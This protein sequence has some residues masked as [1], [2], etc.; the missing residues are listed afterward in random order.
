MWLY[1]KQRSSNSS[2]TI[3]NCLIWQ[4]S[5]G[6]QGCAMTHH[7][8]KCILQVGSNCKHFRPEADPFLQA[9]PAWKKRNSHINCPNSEMNCPRVDILVY[10]KG[11]RKPHHRII[12]SPLPSSFLSPA[13]A[14][15]PRNLFKAL[16]DVTHDDRPQPLPKSRHKTLFVIGLHKLRCLPLASPA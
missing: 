15:T 3:G 8:R 10:K 2:I 5:R 9:D 16:C 13:E 1:T 7:A 14:G 4:C 12:L 11:R 6:L